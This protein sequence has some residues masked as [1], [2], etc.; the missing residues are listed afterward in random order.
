MCMEALS[1]LQMSLGSEH[2]DVTR[3][4][5][6]HS[7]ILELLEKE[8]REKTSG[9]MKGKASVGLANEHDIGEQ[10]ARDVTIMPLGFSGLDP[11]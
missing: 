5:A 9:T 1:G 11:M 10:A 4:D 3:C 8:K 7:K 2:P 6:E